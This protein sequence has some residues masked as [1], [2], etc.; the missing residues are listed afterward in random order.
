MPTEPPNPKDRAAWRDAVD[1]GAQAL[2]TAAL[3][4]L[5]PVGI[6]DATVTR[7]VELCDDPEATTADLV[8]ALEADEAFAANLLS[9]ANSG[10][11]AQPIPAKT[12]RQA[13][14]LVDRSHLRRL[15]LE[16]AT[17][18]FLLRAQ[19]SRGASCGELHLHAL[20]VARASVA[21]AERAGVA[22]DAAHLAGLLHD[23]GKLV[24]PLA[25]GDGTLDQLTRDRPH[26]PDRAIA[27]RDELS[28]DHAVAGALLAERWGCPDE[29]AAT[30]AL[31]HGGSSG[32]VSPDSLTACVQ[33]A[34]E[35][36]GMLAGVPADPVLLE[37]A[38]RRVG[39]SV[40]ELDE[41]AR[42]A[43]RPA[44]APD[45][46]L[47]ERLGQLGG[48]S[49]TDDLTGLANRRHWLLSARNALTERGA[50]SLLLC[51]VDAFRQLN[52]RHGRAT[53]DVVLT[54]VARIVARRGRAGRLARDRFA[55]WLP[56]GE[57]AAVEAAAGINADLAMALAHPGAPPASVSAGIAAAPHDGTRL[58][59]L[60]V[61][62]D[63]VLTAAKR[64]GGGRVL[65]AREHATSRC[66]DPPGP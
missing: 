48:L 60:L 18:R 30:I 2:L 12:V 66:A 40:E 52:A 21:V 13:V 6:L 9:F 33:I 7:V 58:A 41:V 65:T 31:H 54:E 19:G 8:A 34:N 42:D 51:D 10:A 59:A 61:A 44:R 14:M 1:A 24:L 63:A 3:A 32:V 5:A 36:A 53:G 29:V 46:R 38:L 26:G 20:L 62:A 56:D 64:A 39:L 4:A 37:E 55:L 16:A 22:P 49:E 50:G 23:V 43:L 27:E 17:H 28:V 35:I 47:A 57:E 11:C 45:I 15:S 25:F